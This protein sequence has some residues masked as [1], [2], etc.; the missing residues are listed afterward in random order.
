M[1]SNGDRKKLNK[2]NIKKLQIVTRNIGLPESMRYGC[3]GLYKATGASSSCKNAKMMNADA[4]VATK[5]E[6][7]L[8]LLS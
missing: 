5:K 6:N 7:L 3:G 8:R 1:H 2:L 4:K